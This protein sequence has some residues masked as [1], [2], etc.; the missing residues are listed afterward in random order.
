MMVP[1]AEWR[2]DMPD[3]G[4]W[5]REALNVIAAE[6]SY[7]PFPSLDVA[8]NALA[9]RAQGAAWFRC[10]DGT[11]KTFAGDASKLYLLG[12][13]QTFNDV[14]QVSTTYNTSNDAFWRFEQFGSIAIATNG[15]DNIQKFDLGSLTGNW[16]DLGGSPPTAKYIGVVK[17]F[18]VLGNLSSD[19]QKIQW[20]G[21]DDAE[22]WASGSGGTDITVQAD[23]QVLPD[24]GQIAG[25]I[26]GEFG[27]IFQ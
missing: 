1:W 8:T 17:D 26:G 4:Q 21:I 22:E 9:A 13:S 27:L 16:T 7:R 18:V 10:P 6:E 15:T 5:A 11:Q 3:L 20:S 12:A 24:G 25:L 2:P 14:S 19:P 23:F